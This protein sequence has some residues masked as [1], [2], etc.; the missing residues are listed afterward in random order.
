[1]SRLSPGSTGIEYSNSSCIR[2]MARCFLERIRA[3]H[4]GMDRPVFKGNKYAKPKRNG[5]RTDNRTRWAKWKIYHRPATLWRIE[6]ISENE[7]NWV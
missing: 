3:E 7:G 1:V 4:P 2:W 6:N 5:N